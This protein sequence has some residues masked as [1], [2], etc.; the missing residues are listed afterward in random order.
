M[1]QRLYEDLTKSYIEQAIQ[2]VIKG[3]GVSMIE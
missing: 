3:L 2:F 1:A